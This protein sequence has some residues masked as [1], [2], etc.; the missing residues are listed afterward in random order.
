MAEPDTTQTPNPGALQRLLQQLLQRWRSFPDDQ[1]SALTALLKAALQEAAGSEAQFLTVTNP[2]SHPQRLQLATLVSDP[3]LDTF[4]KREWAELSV[5]AS[6]R[7]YLVYRRR[8]GGDYAIEW[9]PATSLPTTMLP[10]L[11]DCL[12]LALLSSDDAT[13]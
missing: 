9:S 2:V 3:G 6:G 10:Q 13:D 1:L 7:C 5:S 8:D 12:A 4:Y 11:P